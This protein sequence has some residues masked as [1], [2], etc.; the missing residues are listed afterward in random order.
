MKHP[1]TPIGGETQTHT[2]WRIN[3][4]NTI[5]LT[6]LSLGQEVGS[7]NRQHQYHHHHH[8]HNTT[9]TAHQHHT[10]PRINNL[11]QNLQVITQMRANA[12]RNKSTENRHRNCIDAP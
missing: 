12:K 11:P 8:R 9:P 7:I 10:L 2:V 6:N 1:L 4:T 3:Q 5:R